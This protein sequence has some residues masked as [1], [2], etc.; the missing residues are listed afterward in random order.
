MRSND[1]FGRIGGEEFVIMMPG[2]G[3]VKAT[4]LAEICRDAIVSIDCNSIEH[5]FRLSASF[6]GSGSAN[7]GYD[8]KKLLANANNA[9]YQAKAKGRKQV[10]EYQQTE[11]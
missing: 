5:Q 11:H 9:M 4:L 1:I 8:V 3:L 7:S 10:V 2:C 6:G